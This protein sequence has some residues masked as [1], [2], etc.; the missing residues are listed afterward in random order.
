MQIRR[1]RS[2]A[3]AICVYCMWQALDLLQAWAYS[4]YDR[5]GWA[6]FI[7]WCVPVLFFWSRQTRIPLPAPPGR[8]FFLGM[9]IF[10]SFYGTAGSLH[11]LNHIGLAFSIAGLM[12]SL[13]WEILWIASSLSWMPTLGWICGR[14]FPELIQISRFLISTIPAC[15]AIYNILKWKQT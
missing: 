13:K 3:I 5:L 11:V 12:P 4:P 14:F 15:L 7:I 1:P 8:P 2:V 9:G 10:F 6:A